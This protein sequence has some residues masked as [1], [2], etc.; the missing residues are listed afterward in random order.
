[1]TTD[2][3]HLGD[4]SPL[5]SRIVSQLDAASVPARLSGHDHTLWSD[6]P[7]EISDRLAWLTLPADMEAGLSPLAAFASSVRN[8]GFRHVALLGMGGSSLGPEVIRQVI[9]PSVNGAH[10][11]M[12][13]LD[14]T[15][16][17]WVS[18]TTAAIDP[19]R[20]LFIISSKSGTTTEPLAFY[21]YFR[22]LVESSV[23][24]GNPGANFIAVTDP[25]TPWKS[26]PNL[27]TS[28]TLSSM[29]RTSAADIPSFP[30][31]AWFRRRSWGLTRIDCWRAPARCRS[32][33]GRRCLPQ[34]T[35]A[36]GSAR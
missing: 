8:D 28:G 2:R 13:T 29:T 21:A 32:Y 18:T 20:T 15:V 7:T 22:R 33:A 19:A 31:S 6:N 25:G 26:S 16:P 36:P 12:V 5:V 35:P 34:T 23:S 30:S 14:S 1:M 17:G 3:Y 9:R 27:I 24:N 11:D 4:Y 10:P